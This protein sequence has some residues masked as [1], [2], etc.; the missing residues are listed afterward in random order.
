M[1]KFLILGIAT[2]AFLIALRSWLIKIINQQFAVY[3]ME[4]DGIERYNAYLSYVNKCFWILTAILIFILIVYRRILN[5]K[6]Q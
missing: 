1:K 2:E 3:Q 5:E 4:I 6:I